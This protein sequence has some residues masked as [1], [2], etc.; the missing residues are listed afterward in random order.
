MALPPSLK[1]RLRL[2]LIAAA[3]TTILIGV[4][5]VISPASTGESRMRL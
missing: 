4:G 1:S 5:Y 2:P 3:V